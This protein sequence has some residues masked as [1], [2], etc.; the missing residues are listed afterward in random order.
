[1]TYK[2]IW[3][4][5][6]HGRIPCNVQREIGEHLVIRVPDPYDKGEVELTVHSSEVSLISPM[7]T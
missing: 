7:G 6:E 2:C 3:A 4:T 5:Q 1:M